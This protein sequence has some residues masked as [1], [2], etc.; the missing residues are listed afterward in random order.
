M[1]DADPSVRTP[2]WLERGDTICA[3]C[4]DAFHQECTVR[5]QDC[6]ECVCASCVVEG[7]DDEGAVLV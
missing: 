2:W 5:C 3:S 1:N 7:R 4:A 6:D